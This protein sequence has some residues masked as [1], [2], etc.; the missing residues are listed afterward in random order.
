MKV[1]VCSGAETMVVRKGW[2]HYVEIQL[3]SH[4]KIKEKAGLG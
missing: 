3:Y 1:E 4:I 2:P